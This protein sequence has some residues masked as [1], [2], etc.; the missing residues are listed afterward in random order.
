M[1]PSRSCVVLLTVCS[2]ISFVALLTWAIDPG[3]PHGITSDGTTGT[4]VSGSGAYTVTG[5]DQRGGNLFQSFDRFTIHAGESATFSDGG[6]TNLLFRVTSSDYTWLNG[7]FNSQANAVYALNP[8]KIDFGGNAIL[9]SSSA[10]IST[11]HYLRLGTGTDRFH[12]DLGETSTLT[13]APPEAFGFLGSTAGAISLDNA[14]LQVPGEDTLSLVGGSVALV[15]ASTASAPGGRINIAAVADTGEL[16]PTPNGLSPQS[17]TAYADITLEGGSRLSVDGAPAGE[18]HILGNDLTIKDA[19]T[20]VTSISNSIDDTTGPISISVA[21]LLGVGSY[22]SL[23]T[24]LISSTTVGQGD[25]SGISVLADAISLQDGFLITSETFSFGDAGSILLEAAESLTVQNNSSVE[26]STHDAGNAE[27]VLINTTSIGLLG[28]SRVRSTATNTGSG[29]D[30]DLRAQDSISLNGNSSIEVSSEGLGRGGSMTSQSQS[31][32]L[33]D[34]SV[35]ATSS[36]GETLGGDTTINTTGPISLSGQSKVRS[37]ASV[38]GTGGSL[39]LTTNGSM[40]LDGSS[41]FE[42]ITGGTGRGGSMDVNANSLDLTNQSEI[43]TSSTDEGNGGDVAVTIAGTFNLSGQSKVHSSSLGRGDGGPVTIE[44]PTLNLTDSSST[45]SSANAEGEGGRIVIAAEES[46]MLSNGSSIASE[47]HQTGDGGTV[48]VGT[49]SF[50]ISSGSWIAS[51]NHGSGAG[52]D[53]LLA[54]TGAF[55]LTDSQIRCTRGNQTSGPA[56]NL[57]IQSAN[58]QANQGSALIFDGP[59]RISGG[60]FCQGGM[61]GAGTLTKDGLETLT[62][63]HLDKVFTGATTVRAGSLDVSTTLAASAVT[64]ENGATV[65][66]TGALLNSLT[67][68]PGGILAPGVSPGCLTVSPALVLGGG[69][70][71]NVELEGSTPCSQHDRVAVSG[72]VSLGGT[73]LN[74]VENFDPVVPD[75]EIV[76]IDNDGT[77]A[78]AGTFAGLTE[79]ANVGPAELF[80]DWIISYEGGDGNDVSLTSAPQD[81]DEDGA[82]DHLETDADRDGDGI[83]NYQDYDPTGYFYN[84]HDGSIVPGGLIDVT[85]PQGSVIT[86]QHDGSSGFYQFTTDGTAGIYTVAVTLPPGY[87]RGPDCQVQTGAFDPTGLPDPVVL[88]SGEDGTSGYLASNLCST[89]YLQFDLEDGDPAI[90]NNNFPITMA[91]M[92]PTL[93][94]PGILMLS[95][96]ICGSAFWLLRRM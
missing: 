51:D 42:S 78:V 12:A 83:P 96:L 48:M 64:V 3:H 32:S 57:L 18:I 36:I 50:N 26:S 21:Q 77:D 22:P 61:S 80:F 63:S 62:L 13:A 94:F 66:G 53:V 28:Q 2:I 49:A 37:E 9:N 56:G 89:F 59:A 11:A 44:A 70:S 4:V 46:I 40:S 52:G 87:L 73:L 33:V 76:L 54:S 38:H 84:V 16:E 10:H 31:L 24:T 75:L 69:S 27:Q 88:G 25:G 74:L 34:Q 47:A 20:A 65:M 43:L 5:G 55:V 92:V 85:G 7:Q 72:S 35:I 81:T 19:G 60:G 71:F 39:N 79:G 91:Y 86:V 14:Q 8:E 58:L 82:Y 68:E 90:F 67:V 29:G 17:I 93:S 15:N 1:L 6:I 95:L 45:G 30:L 41:V 23:P